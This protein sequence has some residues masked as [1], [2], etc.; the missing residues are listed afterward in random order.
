MHN[1]TLE[2]F[3]HISNSQS[4]RNPAR[5][6]SYSLDSNHTHCPV[7]LLEQLNHTFE[8]KQKGFKGNIR[9]NYIHGPFLTLTDLLSQIP[10]SIPLNIEI[11]YP[12]LF[13]ATTDWS[14]DPIAI[15]INT[16]VDTILST[17]LSHPSSRQRP[18]MLSSFSPEV[19]IVL[20]LK[21]TLFPI[22]LLNDS[23]NAATGDT[24]ASSLQDAIAFA[25]R[26]GLDGIIVASE[27]FV[28]APK[29]VG[30][31]KRRGLVVGVM[32]G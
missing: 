5:Q 25:T 19:C 16:F 4:R 10:D 23:G 28:F 22:L 17:I 3:M 9:G 8:F 12:T 7:H 2:Q 29:L 6:R 20:S 26:W 11:K 32:G 18:I 14:S 15:E 31:A 24:R 1:L 13:E 30:V 27:P 21:Q